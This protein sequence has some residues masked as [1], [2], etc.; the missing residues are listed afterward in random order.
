MA[1]DWNPG[2]PWSAQD[3]AWL[4]V[5]RTLTDAAPGA[6]QLVPAQSGSHHGLL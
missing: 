6:D 2:D 1:K 3:R 4:S 5:K